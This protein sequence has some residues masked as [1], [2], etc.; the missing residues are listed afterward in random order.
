ME[1]D[2]T[3]DKPASQD[4]RSKIAFF[5]SVNKSEQSSQTSS[6][7]PVRRGKTAPKAVTTASQ[8]TAPGPSGQGTERSPSPTII[9]TS[10]GRMS[11]TTDRRYSQKYDDELRL[12]IEEVSIRKSSG[13]NPNDLEVFRRPLCLIS[14]DASNVL[15]LEMG[16][17]EQ[18]EKI[19]WPLVIVSVV[20]LY[21][22]GK[23]YLMNRLAESTKGFA[24]GDTIESTTK[25]IWVWC[26]IHPEMQNTVLLLLDTEGLGDVDKGDPSHDNKIFTLA[27]LLCNCLVYN[28][29][30]AFDQDAVNKLTFVTEMA[31]NIRYRGE[32]SEDNKTLNLI[33]PDFVLCVRDFSLKLSKGGK[34]ITEDEYL[35]QSLAEKKGKE[36]KFN[37][38]RECIR[39]YFPQRKCFTLPVPG[40]GDVLENLETLQFT[41]L[42]DKFKEAT[43]RF[44][45]YVYSKQPKELLTSKPVNGQMFA[46][47]ATRY[48]TAVI[49]G[50]VP[51]VDDAFLAVAKMENARV[52]REAVE[53]FDTQMNKI[54]LPVTA[55][56]LEKCYTSAQQKALKYLRENVVHDKDAQC[57]NQA[58]TKMDNIWNTLKD[59]NVVKVREMCEVK[60]Q[61]AY[62]KSLKGKIENEDY[63]VAGGYRKFQRDIEIMKEEYNSSLRD[64]DEHEVLWAWLGFV[65]TLKVHESKIIQ[66]DEALSEKEKKDE[67]KRN[68]ENMEKILKEQQ[69][70][71]KEALEQQQ[72][73]LKEHYDNLDQAREKQLQEEREKY[74][75]YVNEKLEKEEAQKEAARLRNEQEEKKSRWLPRRMW[76]ALWNQ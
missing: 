75:K 17:I 40:D 13:W 29:K 32:S 46:V 26:K 34:K 18:I 51:D 62:N 20:G 24:L 2:D 35:E 12:R 73:E 22:T 1:P 7:G 36:E 48:V 41:D 38:P 27:T 56:L 28:M 58:Q 39:K 45:S 72:K 10:S 6:T 25:G 49:H 44:V 71:Q 14:A 31:K 23:S 5:N 63:E 55:I 69:K 15:K 59:E 53:I 74:Q 52:G 8:A 43:M 3:A 64:F 21:R 67:K 47:L 37:K 57:E 65:K 76:D 54:V 50:A 42:S 66:A 30:G 9:Q 60:L 4:L 11:P 70:A 68:E 19:D 33:L 16:T 61:E